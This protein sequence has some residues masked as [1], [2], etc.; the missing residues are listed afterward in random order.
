MNT[1][2]SEFQ[3]FLK[4][5]IADNP[6]GRKKKFPWLIP[7]EEEDKAPVRGSGWK[8]PHG[9]IN[10]VQAQERLENGKNVGIA[11]TPYDLLVL[12]DIDDP[13]LE[14]QLKPTLTIRSRSR[15]GTHGI[16]FAHPEDS[17]LPDNINTGKGE[18]RSLWEYV[19]APGSYVPCTEQELQEKVEEGEITG[20]DKEQ[21]L[22]DPD[23]GLYTIEDYRPIETLRFE[24]L[25]EVFKET[26]LQAKQEKQR[27][28]ERQEDYNDAEKVEST[29]NTSAL[30][31]LEIQ[32][33]T[34][35]GLTS[36]DP[37]PLHVSTTGSNWKI[38]GGVGHCWRH[39]VSL[40]AIQFLTVKAGYLECHEAGT[41]HTSGH[42]AEQVG[43]GPSY[44]IGDDRAIWE[45]WR[46]AKKQGHIPEDD[47]IPSRALRYIA[48]EHDLPT[49]SGE[50]GL[51]PVQTYRKAL[52]IVERCY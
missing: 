33:L 30:Y 48:Q 6:Q 29:D 21:V 18:V 12:V 13:S 8:T 25:P 36:R 1:K 10:R 28:Q 4:R 31:D 5:L 41:G 15:L 14:D 2:P 38:E 50:D 52:N 39:G 47:P 35:R 11:G 9:R 22:N 19:V 40:N 32:D 37:H 44:I 24:E 34:G 16:Y 42:R 46:E 20:E 45:A 23:R 7:C 49:E 43:A 3:N 51:L 26:H 17:H 27:I